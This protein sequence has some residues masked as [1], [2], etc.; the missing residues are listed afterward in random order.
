MR[1][2][3]TLALDQLLRGEDPPLIALLRHDCKGGDP[4]TLDPSASDCLCDLI[5]ALVERVRRTRR[6]EA[7]G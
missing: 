4:T 7:P 1:A 6:N 5:D 2:D 3:A